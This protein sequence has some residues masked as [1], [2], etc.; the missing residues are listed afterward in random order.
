MCANGSMPVFSMDVAAHVLSNGPPT[1][2]PGLSLSVI[3]GLL[4]GRR[5]LTI[6]Y[7]TNANICRI[8]SSIYTCNLLTPTTRDDICIAGLYEY[9]CMHAE[10]EITRLTL[11]VRRR[12]RRPLPCS[13]RVR[14]SKITQ[15]WFRGASH[16]WCL[17]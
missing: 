10:A 13:T 11:P 8:P 14:L 7:L 3:R 15:S 1:Y 9:T 2:L 4:L 17:D 5:C 16:A 12:A 6:P